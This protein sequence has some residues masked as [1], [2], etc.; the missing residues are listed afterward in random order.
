MAKE[1]IEIGSFYWNL[2][3]EEI[4]P[5]YTEQGRDIFERLLDAGRNRGIS[6][7]IA[8]N[9]PSKAYPQLDTLKLSNAKAAKV[10][11]F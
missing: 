1:K 6:I 3:D 2:N 8:Q 11:S 10:Y 4:A 7:K 9:I 5:E